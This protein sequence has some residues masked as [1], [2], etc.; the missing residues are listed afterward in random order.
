VEYLGGDANAAWSEAWAGPGL[1]RAVRVSIALEDPVR[2]EFQV[3]RKAVFP[4]R[5]R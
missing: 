4:I 3:A 2:P 1:P 5:V